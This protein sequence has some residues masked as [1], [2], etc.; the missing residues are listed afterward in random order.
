MTFDYLSWEA[1]AT[2]LTGALAVSAA[3]IVGVRQQKIA[4]R[5]VLILQ[6]QLSSELFERKYAV[7]A[8][9]LDLIKEALQVRDFPEKS[10]PEFLSQREKAKFL[11]PEEVGNQLDQIRNK[12]VLLEGHRDEALD[13][14]GKSETAR[15]GRKAAS[16]IVRD[17]RL[18][19]PEV[20][21]I[22]EKDVDMQSLKGL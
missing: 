18:L 6:R 20:S 21:R 17:L 10:D 11:F 13:A 8:A 2:L 5:Q 19:Y 15:A 12:I 9:T 22:F 14:D 4:E 1:F 3:Y 7:Y 16:E